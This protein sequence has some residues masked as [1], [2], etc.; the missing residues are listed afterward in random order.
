MGGPALLDHCI[1]KIRSKKTGLVLWQALNYINP[2]VEIRETLGMNEYT[3]ETY[4]NGE[5]YGRHK[6][7]KSAQ[8]CLSKLV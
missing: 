4:F 1:L 6:S 5:L 3:H 8:I 2:V 7:L